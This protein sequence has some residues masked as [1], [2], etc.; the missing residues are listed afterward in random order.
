LIEKGR[1]GVNNIHISPA[2][3]EQRSAKNHLGN[4]ASFAAASGAALAMSTN[5]SAAIVYSA[6]QFTA[7][8]TTLGAISFTSA[9]APFRAGAG[10]TL[11]GAIFLTETVPGAGKRDGR[12][13]I[14]GI[15]SHKQL[16]FA[17]LGGFE[18]KNY[19]SGNP[20]KLTGLQRQELNLFSK[21]E[22]AATVAG[23]FHPG[24]TGFLG[25]K[26][27]NT[28]DLG[29]IKIV[30]LDQNSDGYPDELKIL[31]TAYN[32]T[33]GPITAGEGQSPTTPEPSTASLGLLAAGAV[34]L[35]ALRRRRAETAA[36]KAS[37]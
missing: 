2:G 7:K 10:G 31:G 26:S 30:V 14:S 36:R 27:T 13:T 23:A 3:E 16:E 17:S 24:V 15:F 18:A 21:R 37:A 6:N 4:W 19:A 5:A 22:S 1:E 25:F 11:G 29:W 12:A 32:D 33:G 8:L 35:F 28:G 20:I 9:A 34:G